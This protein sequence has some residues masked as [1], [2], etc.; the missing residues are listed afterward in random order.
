MGAAESNACENANSP[1]LPEVLTCPGLDWCCKLELKSHV[2]GKGASGLVRLAEDGFGRKFAVK[3]LVKDALKENLISESDIHF[4]LDHPHIVRLEHVVETKDKVHLVTEHMAGGEL[5]AKIV[6]HGKFSEVEAA[7]YM[8][9]IL[10]GISYL[11]NSS[12]VHRD[13]KAENVM[14][15]DMACTHVKLIDFGL[16]TRWNGQH[17]LTQLCGTDC[18]LAPEVWNKCYTDKVD[19][20][21]A[22]ILAYELLTATSAY[23]EGKSQVQMCKS[24]MVWFGSRFRMLSELAQDFVHSLL[25]VDV[26]RRPDAARALEHPWLHCH[27]KAQKVKEF[28]RTVPLDLLD[29]DSARHSKKLKRLC[30]SMI[31]SECSD[32]EL[33]LLQ[34]QVDCIDFGQIDS[35][36][37]QELCDVFQ[38]LGLSVSDVQELVCQASRVCNSEETASFEVTTCTKD[39]CIA[40]FGSFDGKHGISDRITGMSTTASSFDD[41]AWDVDLSRSGT[42]YQQDSSQL[43]S[44]AN[45]EDKTIDCISCWSWFLGIR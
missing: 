9:Q 36:L 16:A 21:A 18:Y 39:A 27:C 7:S 31:S 37:I 12:I 2:L 3:S 17:N 6:E 30:V 8:S 32:E 22:G 4:A 44:S 10:L 15:Y 28:E 45:E 23:P 33:Q 43:R 5:Y 20:W 24:G 40:A 29:E 26:S 38:R 1:M 11:H 41:L 14:F 35:R 42:C 34:E 25:S 19:I 13:I